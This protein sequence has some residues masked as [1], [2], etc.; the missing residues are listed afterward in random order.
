MA[1]GSALCT[2]AP[3]SSGSAGFG[4]L[5][6]GRAIQGVGCAGVN[7]CVRTILADRVGLGEH[8]RNWGVFVMFAAVGYALGPVAGGYMVSASW[9]WCF[10]VN[11][12]VAVVA[13]GLA[14]WVFRGE[15]ALVGA[16]R[17]DGVEGSGK[18]RGDVEGGGGG[19]RVS[20]GGGVV[21][22]RYRKFLR[23]LS[24]ID[25][26]GQL[27][28]LLGL[29]LLVLSLTWAGGMYAWSSPA[30]I[31]PLT[32]GLILS[33]AWLLY[34]RALATIPS[35]PIITKL[36][37]RNQKPMM[38]WRLIT[39]RDIGLLFLINFSMGAAMFA[40]MY[41]LEIY[42]VRV[43]CL[44]PS[45]A[46]LALLWFLPGLAVGTYS[47]TL[48]TNVIP[49]IRQ[50]FPPLLLGSITAAVGITVLAWATSVGDIKQSVVYG[51]MALTGHGVGMSFNPGTLHG[52]AYFP[53]MAASV[54]C[55]VSFAQPF[56][57]TVGLT[58]MMTVF[59]NRG[60]GGVGGSVGH[61]AEGGEELG[62]CEVGD[63]H[64]RATALGIMWAFIAL[65]PLVWLTMF[66]TTWLGNVWILKDG[67]HEVVHGPWFWSVVT[68]R[69]L[70]K[71]KMELKEWTEDV[72]VDDAHSDTAAVA[73]HRHAQKGL[74][75]GGVNR[76][77]VEA[78]E[79]R[80]K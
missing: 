59:N 6:L 33:I 4:V 30:V 45:Q 60:P 32:L 5:L 40:V 78:S 54:A 70:M 43:R 16:V 20:R 76:D 56:G 61:G 19:G 73:D 22:S 26:P 74:R 77:D 48:F 34:E 36:L 25:Y 44:N 14:G 17:L 27:L 1:V 47:A 35:H 57:G 50:T 64:S 3:T 24:T 52:L 37:P 38:P 80:A 41:F 49:G 13:M 28:F 12:P 65:I 10:A 18:G 58:V 51:M 55:L 62:K 69:R 23:R 39:H 68:G 67:G 66:A 31:I 15:W 75:H 71:E 29:G 53:D 11:L 42:F 7:I 8:A 2:A 46:G 72:G 79:P 21:V 9:R 63:E